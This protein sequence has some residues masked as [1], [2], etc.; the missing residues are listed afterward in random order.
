MN[1]LNI[2]NVIFKSGEIKLINDLSD[3]EYND[4]I[5]NHNYRNIQYI[6]ELK[7]QKSSYCY[8]G[9]G[10]LFFQ[11][12]STLECE[13]NFYNGKRHGFTT[14][15]DR[16]SDIIF[17]G[18]YHRGKK[19][20]SCQLFFPRN[21]LQFAGSFEKNKSFGFGIEFDLDS[22]TN[23]HYCKY[24]GEFDN[25]LYNG[26][27]TI[28]DSNQNISYTGSFFKGLLHG[29]A[30]QYFENSNKILYNGNFKNGEASGFGEIYTFSDDNHHYLYY[31]GDFKKGSAN[32]HGILYDSNSSI[33][34]EGDF[35]NSQP[36]GIGTMYNNDLIE[37]DG[38]IKNGYKHGQG[39][40]FSYLSNNAIHSVVKGEFKRNLVHGYAEKILYKY[41]SNSDSNNPY[42]KLVGN[43]SKGSF[44]DGSQYVCD[45]NH[46]NELVWLP[47]Y[48][49]SFLHSN[50]GYLRRHGNGIL[51]EVKCISSGN[52]QLNE[53]HGPCSEFDTKNGKLLF[54]G[55][56][57]KGK[58]HGIA[59]VLDTSTDSYIQIEFK[60]GFS[61]AEHD[62]KF[63]TLFNSFI[64]QNSTLIKK[65]S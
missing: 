6:G 33:L 41:D 25:D 43:F 61:L 9:K 65:K 3:S 12:S 57:F 30:R 37:Y 5:H 21:K 46:E 64:E 56:Y 14:E 15:Y 48:T 22:S 35:L 23:K 1:N 31:K 40:M 51:Y 62:L 20:G 13:S 4:I 52:F 19:M 26:N 27:G 29:F 53:K 24:I 7:K 34:Y 11:N 36:H 45:F 39:K 50:D 60:D 44:I 16:D 18:F 28:F 32:G 55:T 49:G 17:K 42:T 38:Q 8:H 63:E 10:F 2:I 54:E 59:K 58:R 47:F